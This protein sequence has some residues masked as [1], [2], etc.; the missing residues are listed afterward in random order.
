MK[1]KISKKDHCSCHF[2]S[3]IAAAAAASF[4]VDFVFFL[5][6]FRAKRLLAF[7]RERERERLEFSQ[8]KKFI[9]NLRE[10]RS[11]SVSDT[12]FLAISL[13]IHTVSLFSSTLSFS[14]SCLSSYRRRNREHFGKIY[15][16]FL[17]H[18]FLFL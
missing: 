18:F 9:A 2:T 1:W 8:R 3:T 17:F 13:F 4:S 15:L 14:L 7:W 11:P 12:L 5:D 16:R 10:I 6:A